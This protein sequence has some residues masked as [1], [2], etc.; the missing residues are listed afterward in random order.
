MDGA[1]TIQEVAEKTALSPHTLR[2]YERIGLLNAPERA[3]SGHRRYG[4]G[5][6]EWLVLLKRLRATGMPIREM[7]RYADLVRQGEGSLTARRELLEAHQRTLHEQRREIDATLA[8]L[9]KKLSVYQVLEA[10]GPEMRGPEMR[11]LEAPGPEARGSAERG[12]KRPDVLP[13][14]T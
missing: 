14:C 1:L 8:A 4:E 10:Q 9:E 13:E 7:G 11:G 12:G 2:Y 5:D 3:E 6:L